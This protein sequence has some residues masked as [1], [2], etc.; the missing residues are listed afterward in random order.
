MGGIDLRSFGTWAQS[1]LNRVDRRVPF[2][3]R[4]LI[5]DG[6]IGAQTKQG[7]K[8][9]QGVADQVVPGALLSRHGQLDPGTVWALE[10]A[11]GAKNPAGR[12]AV[13]PEVQTAA[14]Q[15]NEDDKVEEVEGN[16][17]APESEADVRPGLQEA[18]GRVV[19]AMS[20][21]TAYAKLREWTMAQLPNDSNKDTKRAKAALKK[22]FGVALEK[23]QVAA[24]DEAKFIER[25]FFEAYWMLHCDQ[26]AKRLM[27]LIN[28]DGAATL[29]ELKGRADRAVDGAGIAGGAA[30]STQVAGRDL[31]YR[32]ETMT[33]LGARLM[34]D[35]AEPGVGVHVKLRFESDRPY[36]PSVDDE[37]HHW[38]VY[39][40]H[41]K[42]SD[43]FG[44]DQSGASCDRFM[45]S[46]MKRDFHN[47]GRSGEAFDF[48]FFHTEE[49]C[50]ATSLAEMRALFAGAEEAKVEANAMTVRPGDK[51]SKKAKRDAMVAARRKESAARG[52]AEIKKKQL[53][54]PKTGIQPKV[55]AIYRPAM[56]PKP[57]R[58]GRP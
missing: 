1:G 24:T 13:R 29:S 2:L 17:V 6:A 15:D 30:A 5:V 7:V 35:G 18:L 23:G 38:F 51:A 32:G 33:S 50:E 58:G 26:F 42:F 8:G 49:Y 43:S 27:E 52:D 31:S 41:G 19:P 20:P 46:W 57:N 28:G 22:K 44:A 11:T 12:R 48:S 21:A 4:P 39:T 16:Q 34:A 53:P 56:V 3:R 45:V 10:E 47:R 40:G 25:G 37:F 36:D 54:K 14:P 55:S 9:F